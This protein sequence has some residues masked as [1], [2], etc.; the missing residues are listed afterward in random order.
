[1]ANIYTNNIENTDELHSYFLEH[2]FV[3]EGE[4]F[5]SELLTGGVSNR[6]VLVDLASE[7]FVVKQGLAKLRVDVDWF[8]DPERIQNEA[9]GMI[10][11]NKILGVGQVPE[12]IYLDKEQNILIMKA[13]AQPHHNFKELLLEGEDQSA[14]I[15]K[16]ADLLASIHRNSWGD[17]KLRQQFKDQTYFKQ[18]RSDPFFHYV[19]GEFPSIENWFQENI[20]QYQDIKN[21]LVHGDFSPK[22]I[23][24]KNNSLIL[25]DHEV[26]HFGDFSF[27]YGFAMA[28]LFLKGCTL[29]SKHALA[30]ADIFHQKYRLAMSGLIDQKDIERA[31]YLFLACLFARVAGKSKTD[32]L[33]S[34]KEIML[35]ELLL[36]WFIS[37]KRIGQDSHK[38]LMNEVLKN[39]FNS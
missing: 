6:T 15:L 3:K 12:F 17:K 11:L 25:L 38:Q 29:N 13:I 27:D 32:Y 19:V 1:M 8:S 2:Q 23:L 30:Y 21:S 26:I 35:K 5:Q 39:G 33:G 20:F 24:V 34:E 14:F 31:Q 36:K 9:Q 22:N 37:K 28:H 7:S 4:L 10:F 18:L 16:M